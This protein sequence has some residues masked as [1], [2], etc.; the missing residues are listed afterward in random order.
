MLCVY[1]P[2]IR[3]VNSTNVRVAIKL[4]ISVLKKDFPRYYDSISKSL[5]K[6]VLQPSI[7]PFIFQK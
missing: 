2:C 1:V 5:Q 6:V 7:F 3:Y 4:V